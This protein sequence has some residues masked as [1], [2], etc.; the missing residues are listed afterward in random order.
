MSWIYVTNDLDG[1]EIVGAFIK[2]NCKKQIKQKLVLKKS[3]REKAIN[4]MLNGR[5]LIILLTVGLTKNT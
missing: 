5:T 1:E 4:Y 3:Q 2:K